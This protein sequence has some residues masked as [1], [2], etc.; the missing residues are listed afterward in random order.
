[1]A[2]VVHRREVS[3]KITQKM[4]QKIVQKNMGLQNRAVSKSERRI[5]PRPFGREREVGAWIVSL[6]RP[7]S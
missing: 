4:I 7:H 2:R 3:A 1:M 6:E 5:M